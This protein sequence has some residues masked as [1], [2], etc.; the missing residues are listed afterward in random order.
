MT[1]ELW[2]DE[3]VLVKPYSDSVDGGRALFAWKAV[4]NRLSP[5]RSH[6]ENSAGDRSS[7]SMPAFCS[8]GYGRDS[9]VNTENA[10]QRPVRSSTTGMLSTSKYRDPAGMSDSFIESPCIRILTRRQQVGGAAQNHDTQQK[11]EKKELM[12]T[13]RYADA[14]QLALKLH[15]G[16]V[17]KGTMIPYFS[18]LIAVSSIALEHGA[19]EDEAIAALLHDAVEDAGGKPTLGMIQS[20][21]GQP[22]A[23]IVDGCTDAYEEP[24][25]PWRPRKEAYLQHLE[26]ASPS[27]RLVSNS[28]KL[29]NARSILSDLRVHGPSLWSRFTAPMESTLWY[30]RSLVQAFAGH[31][32]TPLVDELDLTVSSIEAS[33]RR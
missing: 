7:P 22:V 28:D 32:R 30:Y 27:V 4:S 12:L 9:Q 6:S 2:N 1:G 5:V 19:T 10:T 33:S 18:H 23:E 17:R 11:T 20:R 3:P 31:G 14:L 15:S 13:E 26:T 25:P 24:K 16:Q 8:L 29:H 21:F